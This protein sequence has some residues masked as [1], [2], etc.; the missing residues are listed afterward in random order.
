[1]NWNEGSLSR[2][3][4]GK[5]WK[6]DDARQK[7]HFAKARAR[8]Q[9]APPASVPGEPRFIP[10]YIPQMAAASQEDPEPE[11]AP[12][13]PQP[14]TTA[15][16]N[17]D[18]Q[19]VGSDWNQFALTLAMP[20]R[21]FQPRSGDDNDESPSDLSHLQARR[22]QQLLGKKNWAG[23]GGSTLGEKWR[24]ISSKPTDDAATTPDESQCS[25]L[26]TNPFPLTTLRLANR[27]TGDGSFWPASPEHKTNTRE[28]N[29]A[30][31]EAAGRTAPSPI[32]GAV[33][34]AAGAEANLGLCTQTAIDP[35]AAVDAATTGG[36]VPPGRRDS[37]SREPPRAVLI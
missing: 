22:K 9:G 23:V 13:S 7:E 1:M 15:A 18:S 19:D 5:G 16:A 28:A 14:G 4:R 36:T 25:F 35:A 26:D 33:S 32:R 37:P 34:E 30:P 11:P 8:L 21:G 20:D 6:E 27:L 10:S 31:R 24:K 2:H 17:P 12:S 29:L 3:A